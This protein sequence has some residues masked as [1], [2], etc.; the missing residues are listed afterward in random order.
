VRAGDCGSALQWA[1][2]ENSLLTGRLVE[3]KS[4]D[5]SNP[6]RHLSFDS[7]CCPRVE[8]EIGNLKPGFFCGE[9]LLVFELGRCIME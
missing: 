5:R 9:S 7:A 4:N 1:A 8:A 2:A 3:D 6:L